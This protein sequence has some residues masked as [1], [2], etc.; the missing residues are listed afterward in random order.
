MSN[1][2]DL[3]RRLG[4][5]LNVIKTVEAE[6][7]L[8]ADMWAQ[9]CA[10]Q[11]P[12]RVFMYGEKRNYTFVE[13]EKL[14]NRVARWAL[15]RGLKKDDAVALVMENR[16]EY[17]IA[18]LGLTKVGV[19]IGLINT[20]LRQKALTHCVQLAKAKAV[21]FGAELTDAIS[22]IKDTLDGA[23]LASW[24]AT[25]EPSSSLG[26]DLGALLSG[27]SDDAI[28]RSA[29]SGVKATDPFG[30]IYTSGT[31]GLPKAAVIRHMRMWSFAV[32]FT[33]T[34]DVT[35][36]DRIFI[37]LP[38][39]HSSGGAVGVGMGFYTGASIVIR[40]KFSASRFWEEVSESQS[41]IIQYIGEVCRY[42]LA[43]P[44]TP[45]D[46]NH[47]VRVAIGNGLRPDIWETFRLRYR[48]PVICEFYGATEGNVA[49]LALARNP[50]DAGACGRMGLIAR[51]L[52]G[53]KIIKLDVI[54]EEPLRDK[55]GNCIECAAGEVGEMLGPIKP[56]MPTTAF[57]G[58][59]DSASSMKKV[60]SDAFVK[61]DKFFRTG[62]LMTRDHR[63][64][65]YFVDR[66]GDTF[67]WKGENV[68]TTE[69]AECMS[70]FPGIVEANVYGALVPGKD[71]RACMAA[72]IWKDNLDLD[73]FAAYLRK[74]LPSYAV[75]I[76]LRRMAAFE[77]TG[78]FKQ[79]KVQL[80][81]QGIQVDKISDPIFW[82][83]PATQK[84]EPFGPE[85]L[86]SITA[87]QAK[88]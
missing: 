48:L 75:P 73:A 24:A 34:N 83:N 41:T 38:L 78:T 72:V 84:Y 20:N 33:N 46:A 54:T 82:L 85:Q 76:F 21:I 9:T 29:R 39:Y 40:R 49:L 57:A 37:A 65:Y 6:N 86:R 13:T 22:E 79:Q 68:S 43:A 4:K 36:A 14:S 53:Y 61:G 31:T 67:R 26:E 51:K 2:V 70:V 12:E 3:L 74:R 59:T 60:L 25:G 7:L 50:E 18:W 55:N 71:G 5:S 77:V 10:R 47:K 87:G 52:T 63:G 62:D 16:P 80:R 27:F 32:A 1:D 45:Y 58:Y 88:L 81:E 17:V 44:A 56:D 64:Y 30:Y 69:V 8:T 66:L 28:P 23:L 15:D 19:R 11:S 35:E 42:L